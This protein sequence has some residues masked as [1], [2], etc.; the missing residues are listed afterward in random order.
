MEKIYKNK[1]IKL[2]EKSKEFT[3]SKQLNYEEKDKLV[4]ERVNILQ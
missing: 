4:S 2:S 1:V 3:R